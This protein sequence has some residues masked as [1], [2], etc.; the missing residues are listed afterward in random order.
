MGE[1]ALR[2]SLLGPLR[3]WYGDAEVD[4]GRPQQRAVLAALL[5]ASG[6][7]VAT[8]V[9]VD[10]VWGGTPPSEPRKAVQLHVSRLRAA[11]KA[12]A[13]A[14]RA[15]G[16]L[17]RVGDGY[18]LAA[19]DAEVDVVVW[20]RLLAEAERLR[21]QGAPADGVREVLLR[22][23]RLW[24]G[25][26]L[27]GLAGPHAESVRARLLEQWLRA[28]ELQLEMDV[29]LGDRTDLTAEAASLALEHPGRSR[30]TA[31][32]MRALY[33]GGARP[34]PSRCTRRPAGRC[35]RMGA[36]ATPGQGRPPAAGSCRALATAPG[37]TPAPAPVAA[38][39]PG[40]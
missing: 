28:K 40:R 13:G 15:G 32:L 9:L 17:V 1:S 27:A 33:Q 7:T 35:R 39:G 2:F 8:A 20:E 25:E 22:A 14:E 12:C 18:A 19:P 4:L 30:L 10:G 34:R 26:P 6:R 11:F 21:D 5:T 23:H 37:T 16:L 24:D 36:R 38:A 29:E 31:V 3:A